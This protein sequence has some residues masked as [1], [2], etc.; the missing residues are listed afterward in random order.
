MSIDIGQITV[1]ELNQV[2]S[3]VYDLKRQLGSTMYR[4]TAEAW[5]CTAL[6]E[7]LLNVCDETDERQIHE[8]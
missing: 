7:D 6:N 8:E 2:C 5:E 1:A 4:P 3:S